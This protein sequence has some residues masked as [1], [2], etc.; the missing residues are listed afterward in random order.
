MGTGCTRVVERV[1]ASVGLLSEAPS[2]FEA[3][4]DVS[5]GG[6]L[7]GLP[8]LLANGLLTHARSCF[9]LPPGFYG[10]V[11][12]FILL[13]CLALARVRTLEQLRYCAPGEWGSLLGLDRIPEVRTLREKVKVLAQP[14]AV[15]AWSGLLSREWMA[16]DPAAAGVLYVDGHVRVYHGSQTA[17]PRRYISRDRLCLRGTTDYW[18]N[19]QR[20]RPFFVVSTPFTEGLLAMLRQDIVPRLLREVPG[21][22]TQEALKAD[23]YLARF[24]LVFDREGYSPE[25]FKQMWALRIA[26]QT[27][28]K[29]P[30]QN[31]AEAEFTSYTVT[32]PHG[33]VAQ[34]KLA[35]RG[36]RLS[37][38]LWVRE[39]RKLT[40][41]GH[42][43]AIISTD[44]RVEIIAV[45]VHMFS[46]WC[47]ENFLKYM[48]QH[49]G[50]DKLIDY[51]TIKPDETNFVVNPAH[52]KLDGQVRRTAALLS[53]TRL[54]FAH[55]V[56]ETAEPEKNAAYEA[57]QAACTQAIELLQNE[58]DILKAERK[59]IQKHIP[60]AQ[61]PESEKFRALAPT[62]KH[63]MDTIKM[64]AY[65]GETALADSIKEHLAHP[66]EARAL[67]RELFT[68][69]ADLLPDENQQTLTVRLHHL[70]NPAADKTIRLLAQLLNDSETRYPGTNLR[71]IFS[72]VSD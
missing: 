41:T 26:C 67:L 49:F 14:D 39:I 7:W 29:Y 25:F 2:R 3:S 62:R 34:M 15:E 31:W 66:D 10:L 54:Q 16:A 22:P 65:R 18:V 44:Y 53:R 40:D 6:V 70:A 69:D 48:M 12:I 21:Q 46:R 20:G 72:L 28:H 59:K 9:Q 43:I 1:C 24:T 50:I 55:N 5:C 61:L 37:N 32:L 19:D 35:E 27:Y 64:I 57:R 33:E 36:T 17:L 13:G 8:A 56:L 71:M 42:Q 63:F 30:A 68:T 23:P 11:Q 60:F 51:D 45:A 58:L 47:Q 52:R 4:L 38:G